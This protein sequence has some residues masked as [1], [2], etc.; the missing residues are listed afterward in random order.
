M[1]QPRA[2]NFSR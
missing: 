2:Q 1:N